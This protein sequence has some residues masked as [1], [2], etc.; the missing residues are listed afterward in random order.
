M[1]PLYVCSGAFQGIGPFSC[2]E[3]T[4]IVVGAC[5]LAPDKNCDF[6]EDFVVCSL[7]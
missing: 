2:M 7:E 1:I 6:I 3:S 5:E 4:T